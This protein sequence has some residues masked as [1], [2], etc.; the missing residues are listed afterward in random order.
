[1]FHPVRFPF[2]VKYLLQYC[3]FLLDENVETESCQLLIIVYT[4][5]YCVFWGLT[6]FALG[7]K[8]LKTYQS[9]DLKF[10]SSSLNTDTVFVKWSGNS[11]VSSSSIYII[12]AHRTQPRWPPS[13]RNSPFIQNWPS[14]VQRDQSRMDQETRHVTLTV[15]LYVWYLWICPHTCITF[16]S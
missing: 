6:F 10:Y 8:L 13:S 15:P 12:T 4:C 16:I 5:K 1:M 2:R 3:P 9:F 11:F 7:L 14:E